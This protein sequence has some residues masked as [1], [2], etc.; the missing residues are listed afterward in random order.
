MCNSINFI[1]RSLALLS[2]ALLSACTGLS[3]KPDTIPAYQA[4]YPVDE[5]RLHRNTFQVFGQARSW[6]EAESGTR[7]DQVRL[8]IAE[9]SELTREVSYLGRNLIRQQFHDS[10]YAERIINRMSAAGALSYLALYTNR[11]PTILV[12]RKMLIQ[13]M[14]TM[15][16]PLA[17]TRALQ[18]L[19]T[20]ELVHAADD[21]RYD[22]H[23]DQRSS[24]RDSFSKSATYEG[25]AQLMTRR[26]CTRHNCLSGM[27][28]LEGFMFGA[29]RNR[30]TPADN[31]QALGLSMLEYAYIEGENFLRQLQS[32]TNGKQLV[33]RVLRD[34]PPDP[35]EIL[36]PQTYPNV[37]RYRRNH[38][39]SLVLQQASHYW[40]PRS[41][42]TLVETSPL[43]GINVRKSPEKRTAAINGFTNLITAMS[44]V[45]LYDENAVHLDPLDIMLIETRNHEMADLFAR[46]FAI[47]NHASDPTVQT[48]EI[49][50]S[51]VVKTGSPTGSQAGTKLRAVYLRYPDIQPDQPPGRKRGF[52]LVA[53]LGR[54][55][56][57]LSGHRHWD[58]DRLLRLSERILVSSVKSR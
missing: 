45:Q 6:V 19:L 30:I 49:S 51:P 40:S 33:E 31:S 13:W 57:Q 3:D 52:V 36:A 12:N 15:E 38:D 29:G 54:Y 44:A 21:K 17:R 28:S 56:V 18:A 27:H 20:H 47:K 42:W 24:F 39:L 55:V 46:S 16:Q 4:V 2:L 43:R 1:Y 23:A 14:R 48:R 50:R 35:V 26:I 53:T 58:A 5:Q 7:L 10:G 37:S 8:V 11:G 9:P 25:H 32:R 34:P 41:P 22:I